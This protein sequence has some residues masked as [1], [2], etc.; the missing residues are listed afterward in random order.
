MLKVSDDQIELLA[1]TLQQTKMA[2]NNALSKLIGEGESLEFYRGVISGLLV[3]HQ[4][5]MAFSSEDRQLACWLSVA[6]ARAS[7][8]YLNVKLDRDLFPEL[9]GV[10]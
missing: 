7:E 10:E 9:I 1:R 8:Q 6:A 4:L 2:K 3:S 5:L